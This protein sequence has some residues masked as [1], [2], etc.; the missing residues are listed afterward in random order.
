MT[1]DTGA[2]VFETEAPEEIRADSFD[3]L[4]KRLASTHELGAPH[5]S[6]RRGSSSGDAGITSSVAMSRPGSHGANRS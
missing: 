1:A 4:T 6:M 3:H 5:A 2:P